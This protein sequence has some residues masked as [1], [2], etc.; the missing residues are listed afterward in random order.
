MGRTPLL[1]LSAAEGSVAF[2]LGVARVG[3]TLLSVAFDPGTAHV[4]R[5]L[6][7]DAFEVAFDLIRP[8][9]NVVRPRNCILVFLV[10]K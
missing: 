4:G 8:T 9:T 2:D 5:T 6:L 3:R 10:H 7:S 1:A